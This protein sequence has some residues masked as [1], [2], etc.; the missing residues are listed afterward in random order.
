MIKIA[1]ITVGVFAAMLFF[2]SA[3]YA[4]T[5]Q[6]EQRWRDAQERQ[7]LEQQQRLEDENRRLW[8]LQAQQREARERRSR[9]SFGSPRESFGASRRPR[10]YR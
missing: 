8:A 9:D 3:A 5:Y 2:G 6:D 10:G 4:Q 7:R 1:K